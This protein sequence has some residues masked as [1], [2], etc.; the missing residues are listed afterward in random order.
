MRAREIDA[1]L[2]PGRLAA[3]WRGRAVAWLDGDGVGA[4]GRWSFV[5][6]EPV[7]VRAACWGD[8]A[9]F[10][11]LGGALARS[12]NTDGG[13]IDPAIVPAWIGHV[14]YDAC[15]SAAEALGLRRGP[16]MARSSELPIA[17]FARYDA[18]VAFD[19]AEGRTWIVGDDEAAIAR[20]EARMHALEARPPEA[21][22]TRVEAE[23][24]A[25]HRAAIERALEA[26]AAGEIYQVNLARR[27]TARLEGDAIALFLAMRA[28]SPVPFGAYLEGGRW[29]VLAR[30]MERFLRW[31]ATT[32]ALET[33]PIK[34]TIART[35]DDDRGE[36]KALLSDAKERAE[37]AMIVDLMRNDL[38][39]VA[40]TGSVRALSV[41][42]VEPYAGL[43]HL[44]ST[45]RATTR[46]GID[47]EAILGATFPPGSISGTP[48]LRAIEIIEALERQP[49]GAYCGAIG[50]VDRA[51]GLSLAVAIRTA[52]IEGEELSYFAGGGLVE[53]SVPDREVAETELKARVLLDALSALE[54]GRAAGSR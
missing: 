4:Q 21:R 27:W 13:E 16:R 1:A 46:A 33:R 28:A 45:V 10:A 49:R 23:D 12:G 51:G 5:A 3:G 50:H 30:T 31:D 14:A 8:P 39:R 38:G 19:R 54:R 37:H 41:M 35:G 48:K 44:V 26:I 18:V 20:V 15:W 17:R 11:V 9:P 7:E 24:A 53:A 25:V 43:S 40:E 42:E 29:T 6:C 2:D 32:R 52:T 47:A 36:A 34:G 22:A